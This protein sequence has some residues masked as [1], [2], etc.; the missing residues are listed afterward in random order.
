MFEQLIKTVYPLHLKAHV[1]CLSTVIKLVF[2][3]NAGGIL[4]KHHKAAQ[5]QSEK[6]HKWT[7]KGFYSEHCEGKKK[8]PLMLSMQPTP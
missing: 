7:D 8:N 4:K 2:R 5:V 1:F 6:S 3:M